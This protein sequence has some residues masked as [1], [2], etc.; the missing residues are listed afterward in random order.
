MGVKGT[1]SESLRREEMKR[2]IYAQTLKDEDAITWRNS[3]GGGGKERKAEKLKSSGFEEVKGN[4]VTEC[5][6]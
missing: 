1:V 6:A 3:L 4:G 5:G 2:R